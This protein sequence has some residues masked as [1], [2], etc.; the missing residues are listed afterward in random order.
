M[1]FLKN[2]VSGTDERVQT[3]DKVFDELR[4]QFVERAAGDTLVVVHRIWKGVE[5]LGKD[6]LNWS[7]QTHL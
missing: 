3:Y 5:D 4:Q 2:L 6:F 7:Y 1:R